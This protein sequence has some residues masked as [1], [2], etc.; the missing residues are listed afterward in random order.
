M[1]LR[2]QP[3][4]AILAAIMKPVASATVTP[5][6]AWRAGHPFRRMAPAIGLPISRPMAVGTRSMP[7]RTPNTP[8]D[9]QRVTV[10]VGER[11]TKVPEKNP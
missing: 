5:Q 3:H 11:E 10:T 6:K 1:T 2:S 4:F 9:G 7:I 8:R